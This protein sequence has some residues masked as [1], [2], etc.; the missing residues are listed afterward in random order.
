MKGKHLAVFWKSEADKRGLI[1]KMLKNICSEKAAQKAQAFVEAK[2]KERPDKRGKPF[3]GRNSR[4][5]HRASGWG[6]S[7]REA[8]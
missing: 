1:V 4:A 8:R 5:E 6:R 3:S 2:Q 7:T